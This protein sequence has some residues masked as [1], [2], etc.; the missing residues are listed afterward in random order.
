MVYID[1]VRYDTDFHGC[2]VITEL[3]WTTTLSEKATETCTKQ[4]MINFIN[5][6]PNITKTKYLNSSNVWTIGEDVRVVDDTYLR[7]DSNNIK[8]DNLGSLPRF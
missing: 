2:E 1:A 5:E 8:K 7:T 4:A 3:R 6:N